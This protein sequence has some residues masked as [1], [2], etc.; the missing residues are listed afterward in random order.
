MAEV[1]LSETARA[2]LADIDTYGAEQFGEDAADAYQRGITDTLERLIRFPNLGEARPAYGVDIR[3][4]VYRRHRI[5]YRLVG[6]E[7]VVARILH[8]SRDDSRHLPT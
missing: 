6:E 1:S 8:H 2:D 7:V 3:C 4:I 5:L